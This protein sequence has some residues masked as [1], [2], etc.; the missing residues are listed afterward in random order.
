MCGGED[1]WGFEKS[2]L[3]CTLFWNTNK[4]FLFVLGRD[5]TLHL[6]VA[7]LLSFFFFIGGGFDVYVQCCLGDGIFHS[8]LF[9]CLKSLI[10]SE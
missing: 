3:P 9:V 5:N 2:V 6:V 10:L 8:Q 1:E 4:T 7:P